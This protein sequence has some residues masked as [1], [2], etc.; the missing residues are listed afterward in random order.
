MM[1]TAKSIIETIQGL[2]ANELLDLAQVIDARLQELST[3][4]GGAAKAIIEERKLGET[5]YRLE[6]V[7]CGKS[8]CQCVVEPC[9]GPYWYAYARVDGRLKKRYVG[10][11]LPG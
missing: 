3:Q 8:R 10:K 6:Y 2:T 1:S 4:R 9:H 7:K 11:R 5:T